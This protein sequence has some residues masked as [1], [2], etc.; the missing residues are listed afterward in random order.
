MT[1]GRHESG[2]TARYGKSLLNLTNP[3]AWIASAVFVSLVIVAGVQ[4]V[5]RP[6]EPAYAGQ[7]LSAWL[8]ELDDDWPRSARGPA[9]QAIRALGTNALPT[10]V[11][12][13]RQPDARLRTRVIEFLDEELRNR[14]DPPATRVRRAMLACYCLGPRAA[15]AIPELM[16][17]ITRP[18]PDA[19]DGF[20]AQVLSQI[21]PPAIA[22]LVRTLTNAESGVRIAAVV[23]LGELRRNF[24]DDPA[25]SWDSVNLALVR[26]SRDPFPVARGL[27][28]ELLAQLHRDPLLVI[29]ALLERLD[30]SDAAVRKAASLV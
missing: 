5:R 15:G 23:A 19:A 6:C 12:S 24:R 17:R 1:A 27:A 13:L 26:L 14:I 29:P 9:G 18:D 7:P 30:D 22:P 16:A 21:G 25:A 28:V 11:R 10:L 8:K 3:R 2:R 4:F 20:A